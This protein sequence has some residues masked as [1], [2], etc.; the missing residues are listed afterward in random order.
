MTHPTASWT[1]GP[2]PTPAPNEALFTSFVCPQPDGRSFQLWDFIPAKNKAEDVT[3]ELEFFIFSLQDVVDQILCDIDLFVNILDPALAPEVPWLDLILCDLGNPFD[4]IDLN[5]IDKRRLVDILVPLYKQKGTEIGII[6]A[7]RFFQGIEV[8]IDVFNDFTD[9]WVLGEGELG[10]DTDL[11]PGVS[12]ERYSFRIISPVVLT[13]IQESR[14][15]Q[16]V[17]LMK[18]GHEHLVDIVQPGDDVIDHWELG[19][20]ELGV[21]SDLH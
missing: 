6:N 15:R 9:I 13:E 21:D 5:E 18:V 10:D 4:F 8:T 14:M 7:I 12:F 11:G 20:S 16:L 1:L 17:D 19:E 3:R 2:D